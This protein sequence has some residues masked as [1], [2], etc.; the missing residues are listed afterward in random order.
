MLTK[1]DIFTICKYIRSHKHEL[2]I[3]SWDGDF[4][5]ANYAACQDQMLNICLDSIVNAADKAFELYEKKDSKAYKTLF[6]I[7]SQIDEIEKIISYP[8]LSDTKADIKTLS[9][10]WLK[11]LNI[12]IFH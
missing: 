11:E 3:F 6:G 10:C 12:S 8:I 5:D 2:K 4:R 1:D 9:D 7:I